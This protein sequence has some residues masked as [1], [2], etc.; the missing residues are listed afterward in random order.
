[1]RFD[2]LKQRI[3]GY[4]RAQKD[5]KVDKKKKGAVALSKLV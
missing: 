1:M 5:K 2:L 4:I 3:V